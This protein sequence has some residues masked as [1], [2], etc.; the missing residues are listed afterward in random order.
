V[1]IVRLLLIVVAPA[2]T[3]ALVVGVAL[4]KYQAKKA[5]GQLRPV[6]KPRERV[7]YSAS[8][9]LG[10]ALILFGIFFT[11]G[12]VG[13]DYGQGDEW[14]MFDPPFGE[15]PGGDY[16]PGW[17]EEIWQDDGFY[18]GE[19]DWHDDSLYGDPYDQPQPDDEAFDETFDEAVEAQ[20]APSTVTP[21]VPRPAPAAPRPA[22][23]PG[24][25]RPMPGGG[26][27]VI[28]R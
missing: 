25:A 23:R 26:N 5:A 12:Q 7:V 21:A 1:D 17:G 20:P 28:I 22:P 18:H 4:G 11:P 2:L 15:H 13:Q 8:F 14:F 24:V 16:D 6:L 9:L 27:V 19:G 3:L 10:V